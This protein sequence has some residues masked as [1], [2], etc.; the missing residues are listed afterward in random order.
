[1]SFGSTAPLGILMLEGKMAA[2]PGCMAADASFPYPVLRRVVPG[3]S[4]PATAAEA[5]RLLPAYADAARRLAADGAV[6]ITDNC[7][8]RFV[9]IQEPLARAVSVPVVTSALLAVP[10]LHAMMPSRRIGVL[11]F[12]EDAVD[13]E[14]CAA[15]G[16]R[17]EEIPIAV[18][19]VGESS[20]WRSFLETKEAPAERLQAM[21]RDLVAAAS[22]LRDRYPDLGAFVAECT[23]L[24]PASQ[25]VRR[26]A[27]LPVFDVLN[28][29][30][31]VVSGGWRPP[32][33]TVGGLR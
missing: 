33:A 19:G 11:T 28:L 32:A 3:A 31:L 9:H 6:A 21:E 7:N 5:E 14:L 26:E 1:M 10:V 16:W 20:A 23:L 18:A 30:D 24:P 13:A 22:A 12:F 25:A 15:A 27:G 17:P 2:A 4:A 8:G 29:L